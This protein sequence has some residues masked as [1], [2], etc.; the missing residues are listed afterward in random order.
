MVCGA[1]GGFVGVAFR[2]PACFLRNA[3]SLSVTR[4]SVQLVL[5]LTLRAIRGQ[6]VLVK[7]ES[8]TYQIC[9]GFRVRHYSAPSHTAVFAR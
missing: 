1:P 6:Y 3:E 2:S 5:S 8:W 7:T 9:T 4:G